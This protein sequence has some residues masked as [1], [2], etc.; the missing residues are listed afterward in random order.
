MVAVVVVSC[1]AFELVLWAPGDVPADGSSVRLVLAVD[2][3][4][5]T[6]DVPQVLMLP[7]VACRVV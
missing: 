1:D 6:W 2:T 7:V 4:V 3:G 5:D